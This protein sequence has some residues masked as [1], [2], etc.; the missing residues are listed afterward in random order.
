MSKL[1]TI[2]EAAEI[3]RLSVK[4]LYSYTCARRMPYIKIN[5]ALRF[6]EE[7]LRAWISEHSVEPVAVAG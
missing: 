2:A 3:T 5:G 7:R 4:T 6:D 1:L